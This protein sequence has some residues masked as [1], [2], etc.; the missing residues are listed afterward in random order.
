MINLLIWFSALSFLGYGASCVF[1]A[2]M[3]AEF[4]RFGLARYRLI[5]G[6]TQM[7]GG[8][9][10]LLGLIYPIIG[11]L[12]AGGLA[13]QMMLGVGVRIKIR[14]KLVLAIP[15]TFFFLLNTYLFIV[16]QRS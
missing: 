16:L 2:H 14:D 13:L 15:A 4:E 7:A 5:V 11:I 12:S 8:V 10:L 6:L 3:Q 1:T 9:G